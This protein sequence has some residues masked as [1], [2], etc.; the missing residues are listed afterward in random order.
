MRP[1]LGR[2]RT[3]FIVVV[4]TH[5][6]EFDLVLADSNLKSVSSR[7]RRLITA[8]SA[9]DARTLRTAKAM[10]PRLVLLFCSTDVVLLLLLAVVP[11]VNTHSLAANFDERRV[12][13]VSIPQL[14]GGLTS[15]EVGARHVRE[16]SAS[17]SIPPVTLHHRAFDNVVVL[18]RSLVVIISSNKLLLFFISISYCYS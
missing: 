12:Q 9:A 3:S 7:H 13:I 16:L 10:T 15:T 6:G 14:W 1:R 4:H 11:A 2:T 8:T 17:Q 5:R 18:R